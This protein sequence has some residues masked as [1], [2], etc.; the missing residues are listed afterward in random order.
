MKITII[1]EDHFENTLKFFEKS[2]KVLQNQ[3]VVLFEGVINQEIDDESLR[4]NP[5]DLFSHN[6]NESNL[7]IVGHQQKLFYSNPENQKLIPFDLRNIL[8]IPVSHHLFKIILNTITIEGL[9]QDIK[10]FLLEYIY[11]NLLNPC[12][13]Y[14]NILSQYKKTISEDKYELLKKKY[15]ELITKVQT[16]K[17]KDFT[18]FFTTNLK[19]FH[20]D[21]KKQK[22]TQNPNFQEIENNMILIWSK[23]LEQ[24]IY[25]FPAEFTDLNLLALI[26]KQ[27]ERNED[28]AI[29]CG[30]AHGNN[31][32]EKLKSVYKDSHNI[33]IKEN[34]KEKFSTIKTLHL[35]EK[36]QGGTGSKMSNGYKF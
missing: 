6:E 12:A 9:E 30:E 11:N 1:S 31:L 10:S 29:V 28:C 15:H 5:E 36:K 21:I 13:P 35:E 22:E 14:I 23:I 26:I 18:T 17:D 33:D 32:I 24:I 2:K 25:I 34:M 7:S 8:Q 19:E 20:R 4:P 27:V 3:N 16:H